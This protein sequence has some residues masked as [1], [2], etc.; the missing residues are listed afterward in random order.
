MAFAL[1]VGVASQG[2]SPADGEQGGPRFPSPCMSRHRTAFREAHF[3]AAHAALS[4]LDVS[5][6]FVVDFSSTD[7]RG[8]PWP[9]R[10]LTRHLFARL[11]RSGLEFG[12]YSVLSGAT[13]GRDAD[14]AG[15][16]CQKVIGHCPRGIGRRPSPSCHRFASSACRPS[17][18]QP[19]C[20][21]NPCCFRIRATTPD[22]RSTQRRSRA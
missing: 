22:C 1:V 15:V 13:F 16:P 5:A 8:R 10:F 4:S 12:R 19:G 20:R 21:V 14:G 3:D 6:L 11:G 2:A 17:K 7:Y 9:A 18:P